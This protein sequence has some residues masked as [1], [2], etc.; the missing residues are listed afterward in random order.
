[1]KVKV[2]YWT[3]TVQYFENMS[4]NNAIDREYPEFAT[5][6][7]NENG[8]IVWPEEDN[9]PTYIYNVHG[10]LCATFQRVEESNS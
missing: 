10:D 6:D 3:G 7:Q 9:D 8:W 4:I 2:T 5:T 1:M